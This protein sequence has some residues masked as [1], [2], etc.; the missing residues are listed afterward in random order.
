[1]GGNCDANKSLSAKVCH[2]YV[3][4]HTIHINVPTE[5]YFSYQVWAGPLSEQRVVVVL[6][7][8]C[9]KVATITAGWSALGLESSTPVS[10]R[11]LWKVI[12]TGTLRQ[13]RQ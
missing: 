9:S 5:L 11:D 8:R 6:W 3:L 12:N 7:N 1:M 10:V 2:D 13:I 4:S